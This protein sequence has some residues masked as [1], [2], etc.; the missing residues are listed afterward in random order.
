M[1]ISLW[2]LREVELYYGTLEPTTRLEARLMIQD[3]Q[4]GT[5]REA[6]RKKS[7]LV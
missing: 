3:M 1:M 2:V 7:P 4:M 5:I 6:E